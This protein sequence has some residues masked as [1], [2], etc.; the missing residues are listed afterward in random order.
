MSDTA[1]EEEPW[2]PLGLF[3]VRWH[4]HEGRVAMRLPFV[5]EDHPAA[6][7]SCRLCP[8]PLGNGEPVVLLTLGP[9][10]EDE[11]RE[12]CQAGRWHSAWA[13]GLHAACAGDLG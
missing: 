3:P 8:E 13:I 1:A 6:E 9:G 2:F 4:A 11:D 7:M 5:K 10:Y 12:K